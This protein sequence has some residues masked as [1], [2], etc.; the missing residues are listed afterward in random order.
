MTQFSLFKKSVIRITYPLYSSFHLLGLF[1]SFYDTWSLIC[2][3]FVTNLW[4]DHLSWYRWDTDLVGYYWTLVVYSVHV[5]CWTVC[6]LEPRHA[7]YSWLALICK[8]L[9]CYYLLHCSSTNSTVFKLFNYQTIYSLQ[10]QSL[11]KSPD[12]IIQDIQEFW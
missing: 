2:D 7:A 11:L 8:L 6:V 9:R 10:L 4:Q 1:R 12:N 5:A 3:S